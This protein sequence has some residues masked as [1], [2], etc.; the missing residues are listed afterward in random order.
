[1]FGMCSRPLQSASIQF[2]DS[3]NVAAGG[4]LTERAVYSHLVEMAL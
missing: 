3:G 2:L 1:M 4:S